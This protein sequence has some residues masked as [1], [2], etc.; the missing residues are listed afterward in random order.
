M[1]QLHSRAA[2]GVSGIYRCLIPDL[3][4]VN[5]TLYVGLYAFSSIWSGKQNK[6]Y[7]WY[8][9]DRNSILDLFLVFSIPGFQGLIA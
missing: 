4:G 9:S 3:S 6:M 7:A 8:M 1:V 5:Q 2:G